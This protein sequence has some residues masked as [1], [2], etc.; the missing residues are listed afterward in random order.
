MSKCKKAC[1]CK[2]SLPCGCGDKPYVTNST[3]ECPTP[4]KCSEFIYTSCI[5][6]DG[7]SIPDVGI[8]TGMSYNEVIQRSILYVTS[9]PCTT[10]NSPTCT[11]PVVSV[12]TITATTVKVS[13]LALPDNT[14]TVGFTVSYSLAGAGSYTDLTQQGPSALSNTITGLTAGTAYD[15]KVTTNCASSDCDSVVITVTTSS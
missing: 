6:Y 15:I 12:V 11:S 4:E 13:W 10:Q 7:P 14:N 9:A 1:G 3:I 5:V 2:C 8:I